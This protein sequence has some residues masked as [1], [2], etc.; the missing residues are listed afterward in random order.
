MSVTVV[1][2]KYHVDNDIIILLKD[3]CRYAGEFSWK[4]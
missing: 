1:G 3:F 4:N 2:G